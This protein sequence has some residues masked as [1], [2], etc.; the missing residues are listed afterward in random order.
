ME[1]K[2]NKTGGGGIFFSKNWENDDLLAP[3]LKRTL[4]SL[5][6]WYSLQAAYKMQF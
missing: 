6:A 5:W 4:P 1:D 3:L 2:T